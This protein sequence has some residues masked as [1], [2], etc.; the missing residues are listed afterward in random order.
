MWGGNDRMAGLFPL[1]G[2][3]RDIEGRQARY[4]E[5]KTRY[6]GGV[7]VVSAV[8]EFGFGLLTIEAGGGPIAGNAFDH[9]FTSL[10]EA[11]TGEH[12][13]S[14][15]AQVIERAAKVGG[16]NDAQ[17]GRIGDYGAAS[18]DAVMV[19]YGAEQMLLLQSGTISAGSRLVAEGAAG[20]VSALRNVQGPGG[21]AKSSPG[22]LYIGSQPDI[23]LHEASRVP[24]RAGTC[25]VVIHKTEGNL[26]AYADV[27]GTK[28]LYT[29]QQLAQMVLQQ[30]DY[31]QQGFHTIRLISCEAAAT[32]STAEQEFASAIGKVV[33]APDKLV[34]PHAPNA[35]I[36]YMAAVTPQGMPAMIT[37][38]PDFLVIAEGQKVAGVTYPVTGTQGK[39]IWSLPLTTPTP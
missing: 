13:R 34:F 14:L 33:M 21:V 28:T 17:A 15:K 22:N 30:A 27:N 29:P 7:G 39:W 35:S 11:I 16:A 31:S 6:F 20:D 32:N 12:Q 19:V 9:G 37:P 36:P 38:G 10:G 3:P 4:E 1:M 26:F 24:A 2:G 23:F 5:G 18:Y 8:F 25:D